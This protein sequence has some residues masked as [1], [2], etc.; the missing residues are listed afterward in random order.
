MRRR[1]SS[2]GIATGYG[3]DISVSIPEN[4]IFVLLHGVQTGSEARSASYPVRPGAAFFG[5]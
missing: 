3:L 1:D 2:V 4:A 5:G